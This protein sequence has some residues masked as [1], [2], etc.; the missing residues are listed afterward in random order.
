MSNANPRSRASIGGIPLHP[1]LVPLPITCFLGALLTDIAYARSENLQWANFS[2][3][4]LAFG[5]AFGVL[6]GLVG[7]IDFSNREVRAKAPAWPHA[8]GNGLV[9]VVALIN[10]FVHSRDGWTAVVPTGLILSAVT[11]VLMLITGPLGA[12]LVYRHR[13]GVRP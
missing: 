5:L 10:N 7:A 13:V 8:L 3:W 12:M 2:A 6:A 11:V 1:L 9:L 4:L